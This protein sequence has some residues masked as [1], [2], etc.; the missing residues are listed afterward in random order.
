MSGGV[1]INVSAN[2]WNGDVRNIY[3]NLT[4]EIFHVGYSHTRPN[5]TESPLENEQLYQMLDALQ[6][7]GTA[8][9]VGYRASSLFPAPDEVDY[10]LLTNSKDVTRLFGEINDLFE[11]VGVV[12]DEDLQQLSWRTGVTRRGYYIVGARM[13]QI[14]ETQLGREALIGS[15]ADGPVSFVKLYNSLVTENRRISVPWTQP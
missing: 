3:N 1:V 14:I 11:Q 4:H 13:A 6:N 8:T 10:Q 7:E 12:T 5:R 2:Y 15:L 9:Y